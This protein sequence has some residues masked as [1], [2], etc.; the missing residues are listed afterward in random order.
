MLR[1][2]GKCHVRPLY[3]EGS[4]VVSDIDQDWASTLN[5]RLAEFTSNSFNPAL[6]FG[7]RVEERVFQEFSEQHTGQEADN[8]F[9]CRAT[10]SCNKLFKGED[11]LHKHFR[12]KHPDLLDETFRHAKSEESF[13]NYHTD[14]KKVISP[15]QTKDGEIIH[16]GGGGGGGRN[17]EFGTTHRNYPMRP[18][19]RFGPPQ[20]DAMVP[21][22]FP[23]Y[24][25]GMQPF[26]NHPYQQ[27][28]G[29]GGG[30]GGGGHRRD[31]PDPSFEPPPP[32]YPPM[33]WIVFF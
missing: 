31:Y 11:F 10:D 21:L 17:Q 26:R 12:L 13:E 2:C 18:P 23:P 16:G 8:K 19:G 6:K 29:G 9:R 28:R 30:G 27:Q 3:E 7:S 15:H 33:V 1:K 22:P 5:D 32:F 24:G 25:G 14:P 20:P 4:E